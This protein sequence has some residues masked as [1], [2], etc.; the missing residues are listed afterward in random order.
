MKK[1]IIDLFENSV[2]T[3]GAKT[4]LWEKKTDRFEPITFAETKQQVYRLAAGLMSL[5]VKAS[6]KVALL[7]EGRNAWI[8]GELGI[9][10]AGAVNV[11]LSIK[12]E[13]KNDLIFRIRHS[14]SKYIMVSGS[15]LKKIRAIIADCPLVEKVIVFDPQTT[16]EE[17]EIPLESVLEAGNTFLATRKAELLKRSRSV[18]NNDMANISYTSG[19]TADPKGIMLSHRNYT[20]NVEQAMSLM[21]ITPDDSNLIIIPLDH[22]FGHVAGFYSFMA[23]GANVGTI[24]V[25]RTPIESLKNIPLNIN[26]FKPT[27]LMSVPA[28][29][30]NFR[31]NIETG[32]RQQGP[33]IEKLFQHALKTAYSYNKEGFNKGGIGQLHNKLLLKLYDKLLFSKVRQGL[34]GKMKFFIGG[35]ALLDIELQRF[36]YAIGI[37]MFQGYGLS[38]ATPVISSNG[39]KK[40]KLGSSGALVA[41]MDL[42]ICDLDGKELPQGEKGEIVIRGENVMLG[43]WKNPEATAETIVD[44]WLHTGDMGYMDADGFLYVLGRFKSLL[45]SSDGEKYSPEGI[46]EGIVDKSKYIEQMMLHNNQDPYTVALVV[47]DKERLKQYVKSIRP[48]VDWNSQEAKALALKKIS[49]EVNQYRSGGLYAGEFPERWLPA[50]IAVLPEGFT[51]QNLLLNSTMKIVRG[52]IEERYAERLQYLFTPEGKNIVNEMNLGAFCPFS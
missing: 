52:K 51:E 29:A 45:I 37:P 11:P 25:G 27:I 38:E 19:T 7:S 15:Q 24:Q 16:S 3:Y 2:A 47:P 1:T 6:D 44:G 42:K 40:H 22:C 14:E 43:Y 33:K 39:M 31:K 17:K 26:E 13:E 9:L 34:G 46:E 4:F 41:N 18:Q 5:G 8:I 49:E 36:F 50:A 21:E 28:L 10:Y 35:G 48:E 23:Y 30:K 32:I 20:A 12:L